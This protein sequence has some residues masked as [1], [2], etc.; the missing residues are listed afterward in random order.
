MTRRLSFVTRTFVTVGYPAATNGRVSEGKA[1][2]F[3]DMRVYATMRA[4]IATVRRDSRIDLAPEYG[5][6]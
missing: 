5:K 3:G 1:V 4:Q 2:A 6:V